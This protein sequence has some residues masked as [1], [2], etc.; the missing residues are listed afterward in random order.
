MK[1][2]NLLTAAVVLVLSIPFLIAPS[3][4]PKSNN[5]R[6]CYIQAENLWIV[7]NSRPSCT[8][9]YFNGG[10]ELKSVFPSGGSQ[11]TVTVQV[12]RDPIFRTFSLNL[13]PLK[14]DGIDWQGRNA[15]NLYEMARETGWKPPNRVGHKADAD[16]D[17]EEEEKE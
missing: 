2:A 11:L 14:P 9:V 13:G 10:L 12:G 7:D 5:G 16:A 17:A 1:T 15:E 8:K 6:R 3:P 4:H